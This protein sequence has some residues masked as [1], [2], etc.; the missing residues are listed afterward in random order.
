MCRR[1]VLEGFATITEVHAM[2]ICEALDW[3]LTC[4]VWNEAQNGA[5]EAV[6]LVDVSLP[7]GGGSGSDDG[8][9]EG[10]SGSPAPN[11]GAVRVGDGQVHV[12]RVK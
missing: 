2:S 9:G 6:E 7:P 3:S 4:E 8:E 1:L 12:P 10:G 5:Q 11:Y